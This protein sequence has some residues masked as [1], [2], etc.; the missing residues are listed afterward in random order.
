VHDYLT[1]F[2]K[3]VIT[4]NPPS[5]VSGWIHDIVPMFGLSY[6]SAN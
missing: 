5:K 6:T 4:P 1:P 3:E 2:P